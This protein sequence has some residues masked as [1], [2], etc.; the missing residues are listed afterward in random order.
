MSDKP[1]PESYG[2]DETR[3][4]DIKR[5]I[6]RR[7]DRKRSLELR[8][9]NQ[10]ED[11]CLASLIIF[12]VGNVCALLI[13]NVGV[14]V[15]G[16]WFVLTFP[17]TYFGTF[18]LIFKIREKPNPENKNDSFE[19]ILSE[20]IKFNASVYASK[21]EIESFEQYSFSLKSWQNK[22]TEHWEDMDG[23][24]F[25]K[26]LAVLLNK[27]GWKTTA[28]RGSGDHGIDLDGS[29]PDGERVLIQCKWQVQPCGEPII[30][31]LAGVI[32]V[33]GGQG[34]VVCKSGFTQQAKDWANRANIRLWDIKDVMRLVEKTEF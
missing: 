9:K 25:E 30:R 33:E 8:H 32:S 27:N 31:D 5:E 17:I 6:G 28:T 12:V 29:D 20:D 22:Q 18:M 7:I 2:F 3:I 34:L 24:Q 10:N 1:T 16:D 13:I 15:L 4:P 14:R 26:S 11:G 21:N 23:H 19:K